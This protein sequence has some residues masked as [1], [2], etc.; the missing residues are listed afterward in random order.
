VLEGA[1][2]AIAQSVEPTELVRALKRGLD[3][4]LHE[5]GAVNEQAAEVETM[6]V[7]LFEPASP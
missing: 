4:L 1:S 7:N 2:V 5:S 3:P 6:L